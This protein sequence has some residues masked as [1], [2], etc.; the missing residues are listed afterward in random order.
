MFQ[1][2]GV[3]NSKKSQNCPSS[4]VNFVSLGDKVKLMV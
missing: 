2:V 1:M 4:G 3:R